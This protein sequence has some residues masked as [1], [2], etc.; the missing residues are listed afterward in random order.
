M[1]YNSAMALMQK[2]FRTRETRYCA[3]VKRMLSELGH[4]TNHELLAGLRSD[5][6]TLSAT[7]VHRVTARLAGR[8]E[9][10]LAPGTINGELRYDGN[11]RPHDHFR[12]IH[13]DGLRDI[14]A[15]G[16]LLPLLSLEDCIVSGPFV[17]SGSCRQCIKQKEV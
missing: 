8:D 11:N 10:G 7:T 15:A 5:Y 16:K 12:C 2:N 9:I 13:C 14:Q 6:P 17:I 1:I 3:A 4:A